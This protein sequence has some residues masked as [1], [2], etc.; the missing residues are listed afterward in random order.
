MKWSPGADFDFGAGGSEPCVDVPLTDVRGVERRDFDLWVLDGVADVGVLRT[1]FERAVVVLSQPHE[2]A[3]EDE[4][5]ED[6]TEFSHGQ[7]QSHDEDVERDELD[8]RDRTFDFTDLTL[9][10]ED[11]WDLDCFEAML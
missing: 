5:D 6:A 10:R 7:R 2:D 9:E 4:V 1:D 11:R 8:W 3:E